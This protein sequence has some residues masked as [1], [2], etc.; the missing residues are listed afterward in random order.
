MPKGV[1][2][3]L[4]FNLP[5]TLR[6]DTIKGDEFTTIKTASKLAGIH[7]EILSMGRKLL[8]AP[9]QG[10]VFKLADAEMVKNAVAIETLFSKGLRKVAKAFGG[11][12]KAKS[13]LDYEL[14]RIVFWLE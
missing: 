12:L 13:F 10:G 5:A 3:A 2:T 9:T 14:K 6:L 11:E 1:K 8:A 4:A 7:P